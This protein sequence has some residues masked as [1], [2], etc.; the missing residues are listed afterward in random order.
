[1]K[2]F[3]STQSLQYVHIHWE[4]FYS[5]QFISGVMPHFPDWSIVV[6][7]VYTLDGSDILL[8]AVISC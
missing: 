4:F 8:L 2:I 6:L 3:I 5:F 1:M 7:T